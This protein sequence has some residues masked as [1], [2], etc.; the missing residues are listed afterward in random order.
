MLVSGAA[1]PP[2]SCC[3]SCLP[4]AD[5]PQGLNV[6]GQTLPPLQT[7]THHWCRM[8]VGQTTSVAPQSWRTAA[9]ARARWHAPHTKSAGGARRRPRQAACIHASH[10]SHCSHRPEYPSSV[11]APQRHSTRSVRL[12]LHSQD[13]GRR[14]ALFSTKGLTDA[15]CAL[16][17]SHSCTKSC[18]PRPNYFITPA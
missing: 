18:M 2:S 17:S 15:P 10:S 9:A 4:A 14:C 8:G 7:C 13:S 16:D 11:V 6:L 3:D 1:A 12:R 5:V